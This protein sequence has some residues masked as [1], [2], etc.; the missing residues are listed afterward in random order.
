MYCGLYDDSITDN[1]TM[2]DSATDATRKASGAST[3]SKML[4]DLI[5]LIQNGTSP[6]T[7][8]TLS[9]TKLV[10]RPAAFLKSG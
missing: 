2:T 8:A 10:L 5:T 7:Q 3:N 6:P 1:T 9:A 4:C